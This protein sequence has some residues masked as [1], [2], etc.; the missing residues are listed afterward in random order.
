MAFI[1]GDNGENFMTVIGFTQYATE[2][3]VEDIMI[4]EDYCSNEVRNLLKEK[5]FPIGIGS[6]SKGFVWDGEGY[7]G[8]L[9]KHE[10]T[11]TH[12]MAVKW[13]REVH[14]IHIIILPAFAVNGVEGD[15]NC[16]MWD[17]AGRHVANIANSYFEA[18][19]AALKYVL[20]NLF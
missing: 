15:N 16:Y 1:D 20:E 14:N 13:L 6:W 3:K 7:V 19:D 8:G 4:T 5:G 10:D 11:I 2:P 17:I 9:V 12:Q 18:V